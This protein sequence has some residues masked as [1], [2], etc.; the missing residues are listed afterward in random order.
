MPT[1]KL[2][3]CEIK[4]RKKNSGAYAKKFCCSQHAK[5]YH[6]RKHKYEGSRKNRDKINLRERP[7]YERNP[8]PAYLKEIDERLQQAIEGMK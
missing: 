2:P 8:K 3:G 1:C 7:V 5:K 6:N 4:F